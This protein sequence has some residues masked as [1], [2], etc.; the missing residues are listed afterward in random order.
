MADEFTVIVKDRDGDEM[1]ITA[2]N[3]IV[4]LEGGDSQIFAFAFA[5]REA[6]AQAWIAACH[7]ADRQA[8]LARGW[9]GTRTGD[10]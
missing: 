2:E 10:G 5:E 9:R 3:G 7:E 8:R 1:E 4:Y 6:F